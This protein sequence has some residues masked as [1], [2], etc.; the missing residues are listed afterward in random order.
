M[1]SEEKKYSYYKFRDHFIVA[2]DID[3]KK[4]ALCACV[5]EEHA[6]IITKS[7]NNMHEEEKQN[8][9]ELLSSGAAIINFVNPKE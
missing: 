4:D 5:K 8:Q 6:E 3:G 9:E 1:N 7:L 2:K